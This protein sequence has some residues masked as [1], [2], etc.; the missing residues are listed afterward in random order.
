MLHRA[1][2]AAVAA[3]ASAAHSRA[4]HAS[5]PAAS[6]ALVVGGLSVAAAADAYRD[7]VKRT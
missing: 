5:A 4:L 7:V 6:T 3:R 2:A 1:Q